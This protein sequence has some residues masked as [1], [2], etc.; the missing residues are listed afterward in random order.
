MLCRETNWSGCVTLLMVYYMLATL[1]K[2]RL[3][4]RVGPNFVKVK[5]SKQTVPTALWYTFN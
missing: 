4:I 5:P 1:P 3:S 2:A